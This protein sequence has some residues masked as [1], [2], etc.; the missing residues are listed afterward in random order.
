VP[1][2][3]IPRTT[4]EKVPWFGKLLP[5][6]VGVLGGFPKAC[7]DAGEAKWL[8]AASRSAKRDDFFMIENWTNRFQDIRRRK[9]K[10][11]FSEI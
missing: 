4:A 7:A 3:F 6:L 5:L 9:S 8:S 2:K 1:D 10:E 11:I